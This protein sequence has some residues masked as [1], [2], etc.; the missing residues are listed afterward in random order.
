VVGGIGFTM[1]LF[2][3]ALTFPPGPLLDTAK[4]AILVGSTISIV[5]GMIVGLV[6][7]RRDHVNRSS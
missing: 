2:I 5:A 3:A 1:S 7:S 6:T 4:L